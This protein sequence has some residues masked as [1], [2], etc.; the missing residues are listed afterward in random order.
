MDCRL[1]Y[2]YIAQKRYSL[3]LERVPMDV[4]R[5][6]LN[7][8]HRTDIA[9]PW[10]SFIAT[11]C[12]YLPRMLHVLHTEGVVV[13]L[14]KLQRR[15]RP[16]S[17]KVVG[18]PTLIAL[19]EP[20]EPLTFRTAEAPRASIVIRVGSRFADTYHCLASLSRTATHS[21]F[22]VICVITDDNS[23]AALRLAGYRGLR[24]I[25]PPTGSDRSDPR[26]IGASAALGS[27][28]VF[29]DDDTQVQMGW[30]DVLLD[31]LEDVP[32]AGIVCSRLLDPD[33]RQRAAGQVVFDDASI[34]NYGYRD[35]PNRPR[36]SYRRAIDCASSTAL[37]VRAELFRMLGGF[38]P[39]LCA[40]ESADLDLA[41]RVDSHKL[42]VYYQPLSCVVQLSA[43]ASSSA[44]ELMIP[45]RK[46]REILHARWQRA[47]TECGSRARDPEQANERRISQRAFV[48]DSY[49]ITPDRES[50]SLRMRNLFHI[51]QK[52]GYKVTFAAAS[53]E[54]PQP[55]VSNLQYQGIEVLYR[56]H[57]RSIAQHLADHGHDYDLVILSRADAAAKVM[58]DARRYCR[59]SRIVFD[60]VDL[61]FLREHRLAELLDKRT[62]GL[63]AAA[64]KRQE[65]ALMRQAD[66]TLVVSDA[67]RDLL[68]HE[69]PD[70]QVCV[71]S[72]IHQIFGS[73]TPPEQRQDILFIGAFAH[74][75]NRDAVL[76]FCSKVMPR[77][78]VH[79]PDLRLKVIGADPPPEIRAL[80]DDRVEIMGYVPDVTP[81]FAGCKLSVAPLR[82]GAGVKGKINQSLAHGLPVVATRLAVE[83]MH[84]V[85]EES[86]LIADTPEALT[87]AVLRLYHDTDLWQRLSIGGLKVMER[88]FSFAA[89]E[90][91]VRVALQPQSIP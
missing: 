41:L 60:T 14:R 28:I 61:H 80:A 22:E 26:N 38:D 10:M 39:E 63:I 15:L 8:C 25:R 81:Y 18:P 78:R 88:Y 84:L 33:G 32:D 67:E 40:R 31:T 1:A 30:L 79:A 12:R 56:P 58:A 29:L 66:L 24:L 36:Y 76:F 72:N 68:A 23:E 57:V 74:P 46:D 69:A 50:G 4:P 55:Y 43:S 65:L 7:R 59:R 19:R 20:F 71:V 73:M 11:A 35:D 54:A 77:L 49:M 90:Q 34:L 17:L 86:V 82:Y 52:L 42:R 47:L 37:A 5:N 3:L 75:P 16:A 89:A 2:D 85:D 9:A 53:L 48:V 87:E 27:A 51:L 6:T 45:P 64:R 21:A 44:T 91:A 62:I 83:G 70:V 13:L